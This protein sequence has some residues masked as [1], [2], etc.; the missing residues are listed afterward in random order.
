M[1]RQRNPV[2]DRS[3]TGCRRADRSFDDDYQRMAQE[4]KEYLAELEEMADTVDYEN[5]IMP[6]L[7]EQ[8]EGWGNGEL[9]AMP[10][11]PY[12]AGV[13]YNKDL[14]EEAGLQNRIFPIHGRN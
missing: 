11:Q 2:A 5:H 10:Y 7:L 3:C 14:W 9:L 4:H 13:W 12:I 6:V 8:V 1:E